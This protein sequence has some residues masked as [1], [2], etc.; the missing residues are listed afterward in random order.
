[1]DIESTIL[2]WLFTAA[3]ATISGLLGWFIKALFDEIRTLKYADT[4]LAKSVS[5]LTVKLAENYV[6]KPDFKDSLDGIHQVLRRIEDRVN[7][8]L[9]QEQK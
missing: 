7:N 9:N 4:E 5:A 6:S 3:L 1:M 2:Q 8:H